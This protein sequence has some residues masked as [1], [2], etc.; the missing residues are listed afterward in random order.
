MFQVRVAILNN[1]KDSRLFGRGEQYANMVI[2]NAYNEVKE[3]GYFVIGSFESKS[4]LSIKYKLD[5]S[6]ILIEE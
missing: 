5:N 4:G 1:Y 3:F 6:N 2:N